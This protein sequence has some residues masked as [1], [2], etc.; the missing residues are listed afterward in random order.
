MERELEHP[1]VT[2]NSGD[3][4]ASEWNQWKF[5]IYRPENMVVHY[6]KFKDFEVIDSYTVS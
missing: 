2:L 6:V 5:E 1:C 3:M 4:E